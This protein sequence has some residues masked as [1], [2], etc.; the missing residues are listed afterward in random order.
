MLELFE[1]I[2]Y[3]IVRDRKFEK[4]QEHNKILA[5]EFRRMKKVTV[6]YFLHGKDNERMY[7]FRAPYK[8]VPG[9]CPKCGRRI[10][11]VANLEYHSF[12]GKQ[13][14]YCTYDGYFIVSKKFKKFCEERNYPNLEFIFLPAMGK[15]YMLI[16]KDI[17]ELDEKRGR[18]RFEK[19]CEECGGFSEIISPSRF[20]DP[21]FTPISD[22]FIM[23]TRLRYGEDSHMHYIIVVG[24]E[25]KKAMRE[26]G[27]M[28]GCF[29]GIYK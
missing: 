23:R 9:L 15:F 19:Y 1:K 14:L 26:Y 25:T 11:D 13:D 16:V 17:Y 4:E 24:K 8:D 12:Y 5:E 2:W 10:E 28:G 7:P 6:G 18:T 27:L 22:D 3:F 29:R 21:N 20:K